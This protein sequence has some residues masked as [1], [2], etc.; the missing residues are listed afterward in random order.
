ME[1]LPW[2]DRVDAVRVGAVAGTAFALVE[3][4]DDL[5]KAYLPCWGAVFASRGLLDGTSGVS[6]VA[7]K[8]E[9]QRNRILLHHFPPFDQTV[10]HPDWVRL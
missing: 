6:C 9:E 1:E 2:G 7:E 4:C 5:R 3:A 8:W 10:L